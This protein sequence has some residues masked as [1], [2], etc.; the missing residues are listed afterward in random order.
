[1]NCRKIFKYDDHEKRGYDLKKV[2]LCELEVLEYENKMKIYDNQ[3]VTGYE[4]LPKLKHRAII[5]IL[6]IAKT[7]SGKTS[8]M[9]SVIKY[10]LLDTEEL[11]PLNHIYIITGLSSRK[12]KQQ[13]AS[14]MPAVI[15]KKGFFFIDVI[16]KQ[17]FIMI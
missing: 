1:M 14:R 15:Q 17:N 10:Y 5:N 3:K 11:I 12:W 6:T 2:L 9:A 13:T 4:I 8:T 7:Q 16:Y